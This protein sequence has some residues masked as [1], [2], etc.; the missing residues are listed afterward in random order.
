[1]RFSGASLALLLLLAAAAGLP[2]GRPSLAADLPSYLATADLVWRWNASASA[3]G[4]PDPLA[5]VRW[6]QASYVGNGLLGVSVTCT[7]DARGAT[8]SLRLD[9]GRTDIWQGQQRQPIGWLSVTPRAAPLAAVAMRLALLTATLHVNLTLA[10]GAV[11][12]FSLAVSAADPAGPTGVAWLEAAPAGA[13]GSA[14]PLLLAWTPDTSGVRANKTV[15]SGAASGTPW[16]SPTQWW[17]QGGPRDAQGD[18][19][20]YTT[21]LTTFTSASG[22]QVAVLAVAS[23]QRTAATWAS[24]PAALAAVAAGVAA[25]PQALR[26]SH[27]AWWAGFWATS[28]FSFDSAGQPL[29]TALETF[30]HIQGYRYASS[31]RFAMH[32][33]MGPFGPGG[34]GPLGTTDCVGPW[35]QYCW[36]MN[37]QVML[38]LPTPSNRGALLAL[39]ALAMFARSLNGTWGAA[40]G[41]NPPRGGTNTLWWLANMHRYAAAHGDDA[42]LLQ[43]LLPG[44]RAELSS[45]GLQ[46]GTDGLLHVKGC[47][48]P[49]YPM[50]P[51][52]D[53]SYDLAIFQ[54]AAGAALALARAAA[55]SDPALPLYADIVARLAPLPTDPAT[56]SWMVA[57]GLPFAVPH[58]HYSHLLAAYDLGLPAPAGVLAA[59]LDVWWRITCAGP[60]AHGPDYEG[61]DEC[62]GFTQAAMAAMSARL[63]RT[64]AALGNLTSYL[65]LVG[66]PNAMYGEEV[67]A[68][69]PDELSPVAESAYSAAAS[70]Y[71]MLL[72]GGSGAGA[73]SPLFGN[74]SA[75]APLR[76]HVW[77]AAP[78]GSA[79]FFRLRAPRGALLVSAQ[80]S[81]GATQWVACEAELGAAG[82]GAG[83]AV[84]VLL[85]VAD[86][87][88]V[89]E[90][91]VAA[92]QAGGG[93][94]AARVQ[95]GVWLLSGLLRGEAA[96]V[97]PAGG[98]GGAP[99]FAVREA[100]GRNASEFNYWGS[101]FVFRGELARR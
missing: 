65:A 39:P 64:Q 42:L 38:L 68:G 14:G 90:L 26:A 50:R 46:N 87:A 54:W 72:G 4:A 71:G 29:V 16:G 44:L 15:A 91:A 49:E 99:D 81:A 70:V 82:A 83:A 3:S 93:V 100:A 17:T 37:Q 30:S 5:P 32:D 58:R 40:Y 60:Q 92:T 22:S 33:L 80:R 84:D 43:A 11:V 6:W 47:V 10:S 56:G 73:E 19:G 67:Y 96:G 13:P 25:V 95:P 24:Q 35:C 66:L 51:A 94:S 45:S 2:S 74:G 89:G 88:G 31:A 18:G 59:G 52:T 28:F 98:A 97:Y 75:A 20:T 101:N 53:C 21:A 76:A 61:D 63:N 41:S 79:S 48:S 78:W 85:E 57:A 55:P 69:H 34:P 36:D 27:E 9:V 23:D 8:P 1:M 12:S 62:R 7:P 77:P 86:W